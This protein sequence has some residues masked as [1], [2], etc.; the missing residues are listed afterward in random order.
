MFS[1]LPVSQQ[2]TLM[3]SVL[4][5][6]SRRR[7]CCLCCQSSAGDAYVVCVASPEQENDEKVTKDLTGVEEGKALRKLLNSDD[8]DEEDEEEESKKKQETPEDSEEEAKKKKKKGLT[9]V[10]SY[11]LNEQKFLRS[12]YYFLCLNNVFLLSQFVAMTF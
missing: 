2:E 8:E 12:Q 5:V 4:P 10:Q 7:L 1:L 3:L 9:W 11:P 6:I